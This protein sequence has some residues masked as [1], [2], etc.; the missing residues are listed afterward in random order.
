[1]G[2]KIT[3]TEAEDCGTIIDAPE[4][5]DIEISNTKA[6]R[7]Q[8][9]YLIRDSQNLLKEKILTFLVEDTPNDVIESFI[10][11][12]EKLDIKNTESIERVAYSS[13][14]NKFFKGNVPSVLG[15][16]SSILTLISP[17]L[18]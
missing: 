16:A 3:G 18:S 9:L 6:K 5:A 8:T 17:F 11:A 13:G 7:V 2:I 4:S 12:L 14:L 1:M 15:F 10:N